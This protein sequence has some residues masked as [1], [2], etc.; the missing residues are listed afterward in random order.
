M[1]E[2]FDQDFRL[3]G[4]FD[5]TLDLAGWFDEDFATDGGFAGVL[6]AT[7]AQDTAS[8]DAIVFSTPSAVRVASGAVGTMAP[9][10]RS[11]IEATLRII[12]AQD[13]ARFVLDIQRPRPLPLP[14]PPP[15]PMPHPVPPPMQLGPMITD[16]MIQV[17]SVTA[18]MWMRETQDTASCRMEIYDTIGAFNNNV[19]MMAAM[20]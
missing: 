2:I 12:E 17:P 11:V 9:H 5:E 13:T 18:T 16:T 6:Y 7:E 1:Q 14:V 15:V 20:L 19:M 8:F 10:P 3:P 4:W